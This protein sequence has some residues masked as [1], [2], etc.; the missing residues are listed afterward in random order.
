M[1][2]LIFNCLVSNTIISY[3][4][5]QF[6]LSGI[7]FNLVHIIPGGGGGGTLIISYIRRL[8]AFFGLKKLNFIFF[9]GGWGGGSEKWIFWGYEDFLDVILEFITKLNYIK[10]LFLF[11]LGSFLKVKVQ[12][13]GYFWGLVKF[14]ILFWGAWNSW[15]FFCGGGGWTVDARP[16]PT[17]E[18]KVRVPPPPGYII[19][20]L[21]NIFARVNAFLIIIFSTGVS[22]SQSSRPNWRCF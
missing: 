16:E 15:Y 3:F 5:L 1:L 17:Y 8:G 9:L 12:N 22:W 11:V 14:Q 20:L 7:I 21:I 6:C 4:L 18:E 13:G 2:K 10:R 19:C